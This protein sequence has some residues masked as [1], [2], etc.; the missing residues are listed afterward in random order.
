ME[1]VYVVFEFF[2]LAF[3]LPVFLFEFPVVLGKA[4]ELYNP[5]ERQKHQ[6]RW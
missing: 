6:Q 5:P 1:E 2:E 3:E 4:Q